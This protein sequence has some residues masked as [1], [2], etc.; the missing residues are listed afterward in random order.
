[1]RDTG[2]VR[3]EL[4]VLTHIISCPPMA[5]C[6]NSYPAGIDLVKQPTAPELS[7]TLGQRLAPLGPFHHEGSSLTGYAHA[8][9]CGRLCHCLRCNLNEESSGKERK[10]S[11]GRV[12]RSIF[13]LMLPLP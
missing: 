10:Q 8:Q 2:L 12:R 3:G 5:V 9:D 4:L 13:L 1:M 7:K 6:V 11:P